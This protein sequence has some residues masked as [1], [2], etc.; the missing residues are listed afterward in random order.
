MNS[1]PI[2]FDLGASK[3]TFDLKTAK[4]NCGLKT[5]CLPPLKMITYKNIKIKI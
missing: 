4:K 5:L 1:G 3:Q 2:D